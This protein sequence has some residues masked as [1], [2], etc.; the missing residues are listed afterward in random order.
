M[1]A[2]GACA[3]PVG[4]LGSVGPAPYG[5]DAQRL[6]SVTT[7]HAMLNPTDDERRMHDLVWRFE[8]AP[9]ARDW[10]LTNG[11]WA[12]R[13]KTDAY[14]VWLSRQPYSSSETRY[15]MLGDH[16]AS[17]L[18]MLPPTFAAICAVEQQDHRRD[19]AG[20]GVGGVDPGLR[21]EV[22]AREAENRLEVQRFA[23]ALS[24][25]YDAFSY[26][27]DQLLVATPHERAVTVD[28]SLARL[29]QWVDR[30]NAD[31]F[32]GPAW[33]PGGSN[34]SSLPSRVLMDREQASPV[35]P[36]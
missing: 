33:S 5:S 35:Q 27:L 20:Q 30:A 31:D 4:D 2:L 21:A 7:A 3:R 6:S 23:G 17:D 15:R 28:A 22:A 25:R 29:A 10:V 16:V 14:F 13:G 12:A 32:C 24:Y 36:K 26:A 1:L 34:Q 9:Y 18:D 11:Y 8:Q 19:I